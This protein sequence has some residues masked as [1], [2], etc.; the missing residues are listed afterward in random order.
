M[1]SETD[2]Y[3]LALLKINFYYFDEFIADI[4]ASLYTTRNSTCQPKLCINENF[5]FQ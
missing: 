5:N 2:V 1:T 4:W 3:L